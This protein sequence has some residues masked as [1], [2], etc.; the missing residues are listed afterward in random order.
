MSAKILAAVEEVK[1]AGLA[2]R[3]ASNAYDAARGELDITAR[4]YNDQQEVLREAERKLKGII[5]EE[6]QA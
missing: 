6:T 1:Q 4:A 3:A 2:L 5:F